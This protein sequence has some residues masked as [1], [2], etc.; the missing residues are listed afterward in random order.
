MWPTK[1]TKDTPLYQKVHTTLAYGTLDDFRDLCKEL[2]S[3]EVAAIFEKP[4][5]GVYSKARFGLY[6]A[7]FG[8]NNLKS[9]DYVKHI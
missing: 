7:Y 6:R 3:K 8:L 4:Y 5:R 9:D 2:G 1:I